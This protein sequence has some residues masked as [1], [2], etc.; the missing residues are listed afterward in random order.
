MIL[1]SSLLECLQEPLV[2]NKDDFKQLHLQEYFHLPGSPQITIKY[3]HLIF[4]HLTPLRY[5]FFPTSYPVNENEFGHT[6]LR[7]FMHP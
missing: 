2:Q 5:S 6:V 1:S 3:Q 7:C 4:L